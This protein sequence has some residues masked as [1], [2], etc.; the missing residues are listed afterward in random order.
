MDPIKFDAG[1]PNIFRY[2]EN[3]PLNWRDPSG[4]FPWASV[5]GGAL[6]AY[7]AYSIINPLVKAAKD[8]MKKNSE[9]SKILT[10]PNNSEN[11]FSSACKKNNDLKNDIDD[12]NDALMGQQSSMLMPTTGNKVLDNTAN[13]ITTGATSIK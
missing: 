2:V 11:H 8:Q 12:L 7:S 9:T 13:I 5:V 6:T 10:D 4:L 1:D 3:D